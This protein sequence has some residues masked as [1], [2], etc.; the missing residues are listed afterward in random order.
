MPHSKSVSEMNCNFAKNIPKM[1]D[2]EIYNK[3]VMRLNNNCGVVRIKKKKKTKLE[4]KNQITIS[5][6]F[7]NGKLKMHSSLS[8]GL[9]HQN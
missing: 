3:T 8:T 9:C 2:I 1:E 7:I 4:E 5:R 6:L